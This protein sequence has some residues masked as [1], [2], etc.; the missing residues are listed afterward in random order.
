MRLW[1]A[2]ILPGARHDLDA[3]LL[4]R[5]NK[6]RRP[7]GRRSLEHYSASRFFQSFIGIITVDETC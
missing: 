3:T 2:D 4:I 6:E 5:Q 1:G 7:G